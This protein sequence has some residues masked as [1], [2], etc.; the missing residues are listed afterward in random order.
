[1][2]R[3]YLYSFLPLLL[4]IL[5]VGSLSKPEPYHLS[6]SSSIRS[7]SM[8]PVCGLAHV[9]GI[10][11]TLLTQ[12]VALRSDVGQFSAPTSTKNEKAQAYFEQGMGYLHGYALIE[13]ARSFHEALRHDSTMV[14]AHVG[15]S[16]AYMEMDD[17]AAARKSAERA[18]ALSNHASDREKGHIDLRFAQLKAVDSLDNQKLLNEYRSKINQTVK[19]FP[20]DV[21]LWLIAG[22]AYERYASGRGQGTSTASIAIYERILQ[23]QP[24]NPSAHH[25]LVHAYEGMADYGKAR[26]HG[27][28]YAR[29]APNL[30]HALHMYGHDLMK[31]GDVDEAIAQ[32]KQTDAIERNLY[33]TERYESMYDWHHIHNISLLALCYQYQGRMR[34]AEQLV[35]ERFMTERPINTERTFYNKMGYPA[36]LITLNRDAEAVPIA[37]EL[38]TGK[39]PGERV[40]GHYLLGMTQLKKNQLD[41]ARLSLKAAQNELKEAKKAA[42][43]DWLNAW[44][45]PHPKFLAALIAL[46]NP[47]ER[48]KGLADV[49]KFQASAR[50]QSGPDPWAEALFQLEIIAQLAYQL[51]LTDFAEESAKVLAQHD[52]NYPGTH[53][54][55]AHVAMLKGD[56]ATAERE[57]KLARQGWSKA[58]AMFLTQ[59]FA[60]R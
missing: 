46:S 4:L 15:L 11:N 49:R 50:E 38:T 57:Q 28:A 54:A 60:R 12:P 1:M 14:M 48:E 24:N 7:V 39:T 25:F 3:N 59:N 31:T 53:Y 29:L 30:A 45:D 6:E 22:N 51:K 20:Q 56:A 18:K 23:T 32:M 36:L 52:P 19:R 37:K 21:E 47:A 35:K 58:D 17:N 5:L 34:E 16:R 44:L 2:Q 33:K 40:I 55:L 9:G 10:P 26:E 27:E 13:A 41:Q 42:Y 43:D 8:I